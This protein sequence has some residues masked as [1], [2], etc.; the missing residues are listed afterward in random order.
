VIHRSTSDTN[1][2]SK[3]ALAKY[4]SSAA[5]RFEVPS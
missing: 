2:G 4:D 3:G 1:F 5:C